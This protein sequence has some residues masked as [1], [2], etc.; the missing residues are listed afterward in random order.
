MM[1][2]KTIASQAVE[3]GKPYGT[4][5][6]LLGTEAIRNINS[7]INTLLDNGSLSSNNEF[8][9]LYGFDCTFLYRI[10]ITRG[11][12]VVYHEHGMG[13]LEKVDDDI[14]LR[15]TRPFYQL[16][17]NR[18]IPIARTQPIGA[19]ETDYI[20]ISS[21]VPNSY[22]EMLS[23]P[24]SVLASREENIP[25]PVFMDRHSFLGRF[26]DNIEAIPLSFI[27]DTL[28]SHT[29]QLSLKSPRVDVKRLTSDSLQLNFDSKVQEKRGTLRYS[30]DDTLQYYDGTKWRTIKCEDQE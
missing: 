9:V 14:I 28:T 16:E 25:A 1:K 10:E 26:D 11:S 17:Q 13:H 20:I 22:I 24:H 19:N 6:K 4:D 29:K 23:N 21:Y 2:L 15:R 30:K 3:R 8:S 18:P 27:I 5:I 7:D 12:A